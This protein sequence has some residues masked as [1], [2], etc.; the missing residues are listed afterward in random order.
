MNALEEVL[1]IDED[2][3]EKQ[4]PPPEDS[5]DDEEQKKKGQKKDDEVPQQALERAVKKLH[6]CLGH[7]S[8][9]DLLRVM[10]H[11]GASPRAVSAARKFMCNTCLGGKKPKLARNASAPRDL[12]PLSAVGGDVKSLPGWKLK[13]RIKALNLLCLAT[14][15]QAMEPLPEGSESAE[16][17]KSAFINGWYK[18]AEAPDEFWTDEAGGAMSAD[19]LE[20]LGEMGSAVVPCAPGAHWQNGV[21]ERHG[22][23]FEQKLLRVISATKPQNYHEWYM[24]VLHTRPA[25]E[26]RATA[27]F[28]FQSNSTHFWKK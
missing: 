24:C 18:W 8:L 6:E 28:W 16:G 19:F 26:K 13:Q 15:Y 9:P 17:W 12:Q 27:A 25:C 5:D 1:A 4:T 14:R 20:A 21:T 22:D 3:D 10:Q 7:P 2:E 23:L 11:G